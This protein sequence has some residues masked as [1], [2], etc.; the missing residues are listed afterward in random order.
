MTRKELLLFVKRDTGYSIPEI[1]EILDSITTNIGNTL[2]D[3]EDVR[4]EEFGSF[5]VKD[6]PQRRICN[7]NT[8]EYQMTKPH[9]RIEFKPCK[10]LHDAIW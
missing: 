5:R 10:E 9:K 1:A 8:G 6:T 4:I 2:I 3:G 7:V